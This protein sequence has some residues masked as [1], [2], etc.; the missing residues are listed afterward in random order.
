M[1]V[2]DLMCFMWLCVCN[3]CCFRVRRGPGFPLADKCSLSVVGGRFLSVSHQHLAQP[4]CLWP[5]IGLDELWCP[6]LF[7]NPLEPVCLQP[8]PL[9]THAQTNKDTSSLILRAR[10]QHLFSFSVSPSC[11]QS[12]QGLAE[13]THTHKKK[14]FKCWYENR[15]D[16]YQ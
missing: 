7:C 14:K 6:V 4:V 11:I 16:C 3:V 8:P 15:H 9:Y 10:R 1:C 12:H 2:L 13:L 5:V